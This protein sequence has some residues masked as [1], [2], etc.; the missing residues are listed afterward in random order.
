MCQSL[1][2]HSKLIHLGL[3][4]PS[5][6]IASFRGDLPREIVPSRR[7]F[8]G[9]HSE[10]ACRAE[11]NTKPLL[12]LA[13]SILLQ[14][15]GLLVVSGDVERMAGMVIQ[16]LISSYISFTFFLNQPLS[17]CLT[18]NA[19]GVDTPGCHRPL[20]VMPLEAMRV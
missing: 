6:N 20:H 16:Y 19:I 5:P 15:P 8:A 2:D 14:L 3:L 7:P 18:Q 12:A 11:G 10:S 1:F 4:F 13:G 9:C 17:P